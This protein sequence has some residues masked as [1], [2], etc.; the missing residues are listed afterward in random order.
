MIIQLGI[1]NLALA[2]FFS[3]Y[4]VSDGCLDTVIV[5]AMYFLVGLICVNIGSKKGGPFGTAP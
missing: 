5:A 1:T 4:A 3:G 2:L